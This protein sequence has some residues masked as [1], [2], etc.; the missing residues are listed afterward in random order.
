MYVFWE[1]AVLLRRMDDG[2]IMA[3]FFGFERYDIIVGGSLG[4]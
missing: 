4:L 2:L 3:V 1:I